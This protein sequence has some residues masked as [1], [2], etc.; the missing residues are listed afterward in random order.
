MAWILFFFVLVTGARGDCPAD[1]T[2]QAVR[3]ISQLLS[4]CGIKDEAPNRWD[5][6]VPA[7]IARLQGLQILSL[8]SSRTRKVT[9]LPSELGELSALTFLHVGAAHPSYPNPGLRSLPDGLL[10]K[11]TNLRH[12]NFQGNLLSALPPGLTAL[13]SLES[14]GL[15]SNDIKVV[16]D[17]I[18]SLTSLR[19][20][21]LSRNKFT[22][23]PP[24]IGL[25]SNLS[26]LSVFSTNLKALPA[27]IGNLDSAID[28]RVDWVTTKLPETIANLDNPKELDAN[29][30]EENVPNV[31]K[32]WCML[33]Q[34]ERVSLD[35]VKNVPRC[36]GA[37]PRLDDFEVNVYGHAN[38]VVNFRLRNIRHLKINYEHRPKGNAEGFF[39][40]LPRL[41][42]LEFLVPLKRLPGSF[43]RLTN[44]RGAYLAFSEPDESHVRPTLERLPENIGRL[45]KLQSLSLS[46]TK[47]IGLPESF[48]KLQISSVDLSGGSIK[49]LPSSFGHMPRLSSLNLDA[50][51]LQKLPKSFARLS[52]LQHL[53]LSSNKLQ[54]LPS[55]FGELSSLETLNLDENEL[56]ELPA[57]V[58]QLSLLQSLDVAENRLRRLPDLSKLSRLT[59]LAVG[60][61]QLTAIPPGLQPRN[62]RMLDVSNNRLQSI[63]GT[64]RL[65]TG[66]HVWG[67]PFLHNITGIF[68][69]LESLQATVGSLRNLTGTFPRLT[70]LN[71][72]SNPHLRALPDASGL[73][74]LTRLDLQ[75][76]E[77]TSQTLSIDFSKLTS[78]RFLNLNHNLLT[79]VP[80]GLESINEQL[81]NSALT[82]NLI[83]A[84]PKGMRV[85]RQRPAPDQRN[86][87]VC[88]MVN[89]QKRKVEWT[90]RRKKS[91]H[92]CDNGLGCQPALQWHSQGGLSFAQACDNSTMVA[93]AQMVV[94]QGAGGTKAALVKLFPRCPS[95]AE[96]SGCLAR[97]QDLQRGSKS[98]KRRKCE[99][100]FRFS[101]EGTTHKIGKRRCFFWAGMCRAAGDYH[102]SRKAIAT[103]P[104]RFDVDRECPFL[105]G[106]GDQ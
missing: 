78:L 61:N 38:P 35:M 76:C 105:S 97:N 79:S 100:A 71:A 89:T 52:L 42:T 88:Q 75:N 69:R 6:V 94:T 28:L 87:E 45:Q 43:T 27:T 36:L 66:L 55:N 22:K 31:P 15:G 59:S 48:S 103:L 33:K 62:L 7:S 19:H 2:V 74:K 106:G 96:M 29:N 49:R 37:L 60:S 57:S 30:V 18:G 80:F 13:A 93:G 72:R 3:S 58:G 12:L 90:C 81:S 23:V 101:F 73:S 70:S 44:L 77:L 50:H 40:D 54:E 85:E 4:L 56:S 16:P 83:Y 34:L 51:Q 20:L 63:A 98:T 9:E 47:L 95:P 41:E 1:E 99:Q 86:W 24:S 102:R 68:S 14:L 25:L 91:C 82:N 104:V 32:T 21:D 26:F 8:P 84:F 5:G 39:G 17:W 46:G 64:F 53:G 67:N 11:L 92:W 65:L 10:P